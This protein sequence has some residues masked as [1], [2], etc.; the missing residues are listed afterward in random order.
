M[1]ETATY[2]SATVN[3]VWNQISILEDTGPDTFFQIAPATQAKTVAYG[4]D[5]RMHVSIMANKGANITLT[6]Y[7]DSELNATLG[8]ID[9]ADSILT[10][11]SIVSSKMTVSSV[12]DP[13]IVYWYLNKVVL[14]D[15]PSPEFA[16]AV[17]TVQWKWAA[18]SFITTDDVD[19]LTSNIS[20]YVS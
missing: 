7:Q 17:G 16:Q 14:T 1:A 15:R 18:E 19:T 20:D 3:A 10:A 11:T 9:A 13:D 5:G 2:S 12:M 4:C 8:A 6:I